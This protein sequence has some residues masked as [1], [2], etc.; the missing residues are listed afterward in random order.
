MGVRAPRTELARALSSSGLDGHAPLRTEWAER[1]DQPDEL[2]AEFAGPQAAPLLRTEASLALRREA[3]RHV[4]MRMVAASAGLLIMAALFALM[5]ARRQLR[6]VQAERAA[7]K[8][9]ISA[10]LVGRTSVETAFRQLSALAAAQ[11][12]ATQWSASSPA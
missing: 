7:I 5:G 2:A 3:G 6:A 9:Q 11:R 10:T 1:A 4:V 12:S 8:P